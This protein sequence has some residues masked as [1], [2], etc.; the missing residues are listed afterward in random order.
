MNEL[1][2]TDVDALRQAFTAA[3]YT[4]EGVA[5]RLGAQANGALARNETTL[6]GRR[7]AAVTRS[8]R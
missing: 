4:V 5:D 3:G 7:T 2:G 1:T 6:A 8:T